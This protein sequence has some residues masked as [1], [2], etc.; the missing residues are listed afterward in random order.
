[1]QKDNGSGGVKDVARYQ[2]MLCKSARRDC[3]LFYIKFIY[4]FHII[5]LD[6]YC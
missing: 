5:Y 1:M 2:T 4:I 3:C 6:G